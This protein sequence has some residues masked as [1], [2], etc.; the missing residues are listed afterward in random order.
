M[1]LPEKPTSTTSGYNPSMPVVHSLHTNLLIQNGWVR[2]GNT[3]HHQNDVLVYN[4]VKW[5]LN[6]SKECQFLEDLNK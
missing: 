3:Y 2:E 6:G 4:G 1:E 5:I